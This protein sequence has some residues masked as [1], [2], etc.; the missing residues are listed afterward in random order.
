V[1][2]SLGSNGLF[3]GYAIGSIALYQT[4]STHTMNDL[5][6][7]FAVKSCFGFNCNNF[8]EGVFRLCVDPKERNLVE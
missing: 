8:V 4:K 2:I 1:I 5:C 3:V 6:S 7:F